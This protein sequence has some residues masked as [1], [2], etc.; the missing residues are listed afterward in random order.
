MSVNLG[1]IAAAL[2]SLGNL[3]SLGGHQ[4]DIYNAPNTIRFSGNV[5]F[6]KLIDNTT[7]YLVVRRVD[8]YKKVVETYERTGYKVEQ[9]FSFNISEDCTLDVLVSDLKLDNRYYFNPVQATFQNIVIKNLSVP[10]SVKDNIA[11]RFGNGLRFW[12]VDQDDVELGNFK[13]DNVERSALE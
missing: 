11:L 12:N 1:L 13:Y 8:D 4:Y 10:Q 7:P 9:D 6:Q 3:T 5:D 2:Q